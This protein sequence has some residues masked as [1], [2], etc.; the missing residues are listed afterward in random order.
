MARKKF[1]SR[2]GGAHKLLAPQVDPQK[3]LPEAEEL[4]LKAASL[5]READHLFAKAERTEDAQKRQ[6]AG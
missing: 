5:L 1:T 6:P 2:Q 4:K 3:L